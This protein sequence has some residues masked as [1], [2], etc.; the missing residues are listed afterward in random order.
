MTTNLDY[1]NDALDR[2]SQAPAEVHL[3]QPDWSANPTV[4][5]LQAR[6]ADHHGHYLA[7]A[8]A[9]AALVQPLV[10]TTPARP[11]P[12]SPVRLMPALGI[13]GGIALALVVIARLV[14]APPA[15]EA[16]RT[17]TLVPIVAGIEGAPGYP[18]PL[19]QDPTTP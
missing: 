4:A 17:P 7:A 6:Y 19:P 16:V 2:W 12:P 8:W 9:E 13:L 10:A 5:F 14:M 15:Q 3:A 11:C 18:L 1:L